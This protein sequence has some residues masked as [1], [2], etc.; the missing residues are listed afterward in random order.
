MQNSIISDSKP[1]HSRGKALSKNTSL[2]NSVIIDLSPKTASKRK[3][4][5]NSI[6]PKEDPYPEG[7]PSLHPEARTSDFSNSSIG[8]FFLHNFSSTNK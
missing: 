5:K 7:R 2:N 1:G 3:E 6:W 8:N 4:P